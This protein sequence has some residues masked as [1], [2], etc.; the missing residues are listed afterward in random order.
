MIIKILKSI[1]LKVDN[2]DKLSALE[3]ILRAH[4]EAKHLLWMPFEVASQLRKESQLSAFSQRILNSLMGE[5]NEGIGIE[6]DLNFYTIVN[7]DDKFKNTPS[8]NIS[9]LGYGHFTN[10]S[11]TQ[12]AILLTEN[13]LDAQAYL[14]GARTYIKKIRKSGVNISLEI[15]PGGGS[16]IYNSYNRLSNSRRFFICIVDS[17]KN[18]PN[19]ALGS[20]ASRFSNIPQGFNGKNHLSILDCHEIE[21]IIPLAILGDVSEQLLADSIVHQPKHIDYRKYPDH[22][23]G[24]KLS[25]ARKLDSH[26]QQ[27]YWKE[28]YEEDDD[29]L[30]CPSFGN[31][32]LE[33]CINF[34]NTLSPKKSVAKIHDQHDEYWLE[35]A[36]TV[37]S[38]GIS[39]RGLGS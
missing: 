37:A 14:W 20:T 12:E 4:G 31:G 7:F 27:E 6:N 19:A 18:H 5:I 33:N 21:N 24:L 17:D 1:N 35:L 38:W 29:L 10:S 25:S 32:L 2:N 26:H 8:K 22:K 3:N 15:Q 28:F 39:S 36:K 34:M 30:L 23:S 11:W 9:E 16:T 13:E